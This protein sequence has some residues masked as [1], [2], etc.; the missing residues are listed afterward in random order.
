[1]AYIKPCRRCGLRKRG[2][3]KYLEIC[4]SIKKTTITAAKIKCDFL[5]EMFSP[6]TRVAADCG[7]VNTV[8]DSCSGEYQTFREE[9]IN[10]TVMSW[11]NGKVVICL[12]ESWHPDGRYHRKVWPDHL[13]LLDEPR[14][15]V[16]SYCGHPL[17]RLEDKNIFCPECNH[18]KTEVFWCGGARKDGG[19]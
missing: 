18:G 13:H 4:K 12:D 10:G 3:V 9:A 8:F 19:R 2:C 7:S 17:D 15:A 5:T 11:S 16:C 14:V 1:M 6:G